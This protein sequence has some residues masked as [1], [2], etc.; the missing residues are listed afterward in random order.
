MDTAV[1]GDRFRE[2]FNGRAVAASGAARARQRC[3]QR[4]G[5]PSWCVAGEAGVLRRGHVH[6]PCH[7]VPSGTRCPDRAAEAWPRRQARRVADR[8]G[9][10]PA[11]SG[12]RRR[13][14]PV[15]H[16]GLRAQKQ[17]E[18]YVAR[19][20]A[21]LEDNSRCRRT[22]QPAGR[23]D[24]DQ[25]QGDVQ[26]S[27]ADARSAG[28]APVRPGQY[29][30]ATAYVREAGLRHKI[31][32]PLFGHRARRQEV[33]ERSFRRELP[34]KPLQDRLSRHRGCVSGIPDRA[35]RG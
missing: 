4:D 7:G 29:S 10:P 20:E 12:P 8:S 28:L 16:R 15:Q 26:R 30:R 3:G 35:R 27:I 14:C 5:R 18:P 9:R 19:T 13:R 2:M 22:G 33:L 6:V 11:R 24:P 31:Q 21:V 1:C 17:R 32:G 34:G 23:N 25:S